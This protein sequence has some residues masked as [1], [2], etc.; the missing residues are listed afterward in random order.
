MEQKE[1]QMKEVT[2]QKRQAI[3]FARDAVMSVDDKAPY[4]RYFKDKNGKI[5]AKDVPIVDNKK[6]KETEYKYYIK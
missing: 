5:I 3:T 1:T 4:T 6:R 2:R